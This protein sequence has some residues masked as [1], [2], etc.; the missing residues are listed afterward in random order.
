[1]LFVC[2]GNSYRSPLAEALL[3]KFNPNLEVDSAGT[4]PSASISKEAAE[5]LAEEEAENFLKKT[6]QPL[7][8]NPSRITI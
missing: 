6:P 3:K 5:Y 1:M 7:E 2:S 4:R 8:E